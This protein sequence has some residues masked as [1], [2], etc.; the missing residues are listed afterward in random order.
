MGMKL[1]VV[2]IRTDSEFIVKSVFPPNAEEL[3]I[4]CRKA[5]VKF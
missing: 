4:Y 3:D 1:K 5:N 2:Y